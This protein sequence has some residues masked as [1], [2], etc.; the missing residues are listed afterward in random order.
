ML[1]DEDHSTLQNKNHKI[2]FFKAL[3]WITT[4][5]LLKISGYF[6]IL[7]IRQGTCPPVKFLAQGSCPTN[8]VLPNPRLVS[9]TFH[10]DT[11]VPSQLLTQFFTIFAQFV[12]HDITIAAT[13]TVP[14]CCGTPSDTDRCAPITVSNDP[15][16]PAGKC[17]NFARSLIF[18]EV[19]GCEVSQTPIFDLA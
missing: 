2:C 9:A 4:V 18:C 8:C 1:S 13:Y 16:Y 3:I 19:I 11:D 10:K 15:F 7:N 14:D 6:L 12:D 17:L 5:V